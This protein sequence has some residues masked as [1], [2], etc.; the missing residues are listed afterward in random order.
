MAVF[1]AGVEY[2]PE[3]ES[4]SDDEEL[5][6]LV[7]FL[8][9]RWSVLSGA[10][11]LDELGARL[12]ASLSTRGEPFERLAYAPP[13]TFAFATGRHAVLAVNWHRDD[14]ESWIGAVAKNRRRGLVLITIDDVAEEDRAALPFCE[15]SV[16][17]VL[18]SNALE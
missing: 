1:R 8:A 15:G 10:V 11:S 9:S 5:N 14:L 6:G 7:D 17:V 13:T 18:I 16:D 3:Q 4:V 2:F 12:V